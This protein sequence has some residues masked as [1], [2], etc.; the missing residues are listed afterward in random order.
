MEASEIF[1]FTSGKSEGWGAVL[2]ES[3][4]SGCAVVANKAIGSVPYL[5]KDG[6]NGLT[7]NGTEKDFY[8]KVKGVLGNR[9]T[10][11][12]LGKS[13]YITLLKTWNADVAARNLVEIILN[14]DNDSLG[15][16]GPCSLERN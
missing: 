12:K 8:E 6:E 16:E 9:K 2:N 7:Y 3:M 11:A 4:N 5:I 14:G 1:L 10:I 15:G 13:A